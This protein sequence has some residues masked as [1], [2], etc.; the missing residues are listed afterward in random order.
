V[1]IGNLLGG[2]TQA[3]SI[4]NTL[5]N[6]GSGANIRVAGGTFAEDVVVNNPFNLYFSGSTLRS[7][8]RWAAAPT[9]PASA[10]P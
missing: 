5:G 2:G 9:V 6:A 10:A 7:L 1:G 8:A 3:M 4:D